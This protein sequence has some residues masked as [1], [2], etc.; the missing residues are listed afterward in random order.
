L[1]AA[2]CVFLEIAV[3]TARLKIFG[4]IM[5]S[6]ELLLALADEETLE[7]ARRM[8]G[9]PRLALLLAKAA[10]ET[11]GGAALDA[12]AVAEILG[13]PVKQGT[14][15]FISSDGLV[16]T[17]FHVISGAA[18]VAAVGNNGSVFIFESLVSHPANIDLAILKFRANYV[19]FLKL[20]ESAEKVEGERVI[21]IGNPTGLSGTVSDGIISAFRENRSMIQITAPISHGSS[22]SPVLDDSGSVI[23]VATLIQA[24]GQNL[25]FAIAVEEVSAALGSPTPEVTPPIDPLP[26]EPSRGQGGEAYSPPK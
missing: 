3:D 5:T 11:E 25:N 24:E 4:Q 18:S 17:N 2:L 13:S 12:E 21:V 9:K 1:G 16:V 15:F 6:L 22:G 10:I 23:G 7:F 8:I 19:P 20:G 14:G 26:A